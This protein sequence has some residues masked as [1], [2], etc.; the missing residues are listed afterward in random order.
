MSKKSTDQQSYW[1]LNLDKLLYNRCG[2][3]QEWIGPIGSWTEH[4]LWDQSMWLG[5]PRMAVKLPQMIERSNRTREE[6]EAKDPTTARDKSAIHPVPTATNN[7]AL[8]ALPNKTY[9]RP[10]YLSLFSLWPRLVSKN[11]LINFDVS[12]LTFLPCH[13]Y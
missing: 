6:E 11:S 2:E 8:L 3:D 1:I 13:F 9:T 5:T 7:T 4:S 12:G 10:H